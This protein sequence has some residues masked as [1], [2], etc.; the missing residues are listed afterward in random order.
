MCL[1][2]L[3]RLGIFICFLWWRPTVRLYSESIVEQ[4]TSTPLMTSKRPPIAP[5]APGIGK[6][7]SAF[8]TTARHS[9]RELFAVFKLDCE[10]EKN[11]R[12]PSLFLKLGVGDGLEEEDAMVV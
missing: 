6:P 8:S 9:L 5:F 2:T 10:G 1:Q 3:E 4:L 12:S 7:S 11:A